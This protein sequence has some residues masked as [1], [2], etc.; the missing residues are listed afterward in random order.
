MAA[1]IENRIR[2]LGEVTER[3]VD[4]WSARPHVGAPV[5]QWRDPGRQRCDARG[6]PSP[7]P[8]RCSTEIGIAFL[9][10]REP[11]ANGTFGASD[12]PPVS[13]HIRKVFNGPLVLNSDYVLEN[14]AAA[15][16]EGRADAISFGRTFL[17]NPDLPARLRTDAPLTPAIPARGTARAPRAIPTIRRWRTPKLRLRLGLTGWAGRVAQARPAAPR[18]AP[19]PR[20]AFGTRTAECP[21]RGT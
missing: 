3:L 16:A 13:P 2:L 7:P 4:V 15:M 18:C 17:A 11:P 6:R 8:P 21:P 19:G 5:A 20:F 14:A 1:A 12:T 9:E 10:L